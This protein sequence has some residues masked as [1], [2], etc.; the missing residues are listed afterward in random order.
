MTHERAADALL[1]LTITVPVFVLGEPPAEPGLPLLWIQV[2]AVP[3]LAL[4]VA[5]GRRQP[6]I[7]ACVP[8]GLGLAATPE[9]YTSS[10]MIAQIVLAFLLGRRS[11]RLRTGLLFCAAV[12]LAGLA[13]VGFTGVGAEGWFDVVVTVLLN[14]LLP[15]LAG[16]YVRQHDDLV[17]AGWELAQRLERE[18]DLIAGQMR[19]VERSRIARDMHDSLGHELSMIALRAAALQVSPELG[20][21]SR[22]AAGELREAAAD[23]TDRLREI[24]GVLR[25]DSEPP[26]LHP[27]GDTIGALVERAAASG[28]AV[29]MEGM[30]D[31]LPPMADRAAYRVV[32]EALTNAAKHARGAAVTVRLAVDASTDE[33]V[34]GVVNG[35]P[36]SRTAPNLPTVDAASG[37][38]GLVSLDERVRLVGGR[39]RAGPV[40]VG[41]A[42]SA[43]LPLS[44][45][46]AVTAPDSRRE[47]AVARRN[48]RRSVLDA[49]WVP[50][51]A[52]ALLLAVMFVQDRFAG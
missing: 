23:A 24:I 52:A 3:L 49:I 9:L 40:G 13:V 28:L 32:Q 45:R 11:V 39:L 33:A 27:T 37:G 2:A 38:H 10:F 42:V 46:T 7:A 26:P 4:A 43:R 6:V 12:C 51:V 30:L 35:P 17:R 36:P 19:L 5:V 21:G 31:P 29:T 15:V 34:I 47:L 41:F 44:A 50:A 14:I 8:V 16:R 22:R 48:V 1:W 25:Q 20:E 18:Q